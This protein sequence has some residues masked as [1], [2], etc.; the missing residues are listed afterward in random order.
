MSKKYLLGLDLGTDSVGWCL[1][2][3]NSKII[4]KNGKYLWGVRLFDEA[5]DCK[6]RRSYRTNR[7]R[8]ARRNQRIDLLQ[9]LFAEEINKVDSNFYIRLQFSQIKK[10][11]SELNNIHFD[12]MQTLFNDPNFNDKAYYEKYPTIYHLRNELMNNSETKFD[13]RLIYLAIAH[14]LKHRGN[15]LY[16]NLKIEDNKID[17]KTLIKEDYKIIFE[18]LGKE[19][20]EDFIDNITNKTIIDFNNKHKKTD[21]KEFLQDEI[22][23]KDLINEEDYQVVKNVYIPLLSGSDLKLDTLIKIKNVLDEDTYDELEDDIKKIDLTFSKEEFEDNYDKVMK[24]AFLKDDN[25]KYFELIKNF[26]HIYN[27][28]SLNKLLNDSSSISESMIKKYELHNSQLNEFKNYLKDNNL[29][30]TYYEIFRKE[31]DKTNNYVKYVG[32]NSLN[33]NTSRF[34]KCK[35]DDFYDF[36]KKIIKKDCNEEDSYIKKALELIENK[37]F[38]TKQRTSSNGLLPYQLVKYELERILENQSKFYPFLLEEDEYGSVKEKVIKILT[39]KVPYY[40]GPLVRKENDEN[41][42]Y[43]KFSWAEFK[44]NETKITPWNF[45]KIIDTKASASNFIKR[46]QNKCTYLHNEFCLPK[47][48]PLIQYEN[49]L[50]E[51]NKMVVNGKQ[52]DFEEKMDLLTNVYLKNDKVNKSKIEEF[53]KSK[54]NNKVTLS[55]ISSDHEFSLQHSLSSFNQLS[56]ILNLNESE[57]KNYLETGLNNRLEDIVWAISIYEDKTLLVDY[58]KDNSSRL[59]I[60]ENQIKQLKSLSYNGFSRLSKKLLT[61]S[62]CNENGEIICESMIHSMIYSNN[63]FMEL[64]KNDSPYIEFINNENQKNLENKDSKDFVKNYIND[65]YV[66]PGMKR[67]LIQS[68]KIIEEL[69]KIIGN[70][71][72]EYY[73]EC[74][75]TN[76]EKDKNKEKLS[77]KADL[78]KKCKELTSILNNKVDVDEFKKLLNKTEDT[79]FRSDAIY[80]YFTQLGRD[81]YTGEKIDFKNG[82]YDIDHIYPQSLIKDD[83]LNNRVLT[84]KSNNNKKTDQYPINYDALCKSGNKEFVFKLQNEL[85]KLGLISKEKLNRLQRQTEL[86]NEELFNFTNRQIVYTNQSVKALKDMLID[87]K[88]TKEH[89]IKVIMSKAN[90]VSDFRKKYDI[91][92]SRDANNFHHA[93]DAFLNVVVGR[94]IDTYFNNIIYPMLYSKNKVDLKRYTTNVQ[95]IFDDY[96]EGHKNNILDSNNNLVWDYSNSL[97]YI[98]KEV[99]HNYNI[100]LTTRTYIDNNLFSKV[101]IKPAKDLNNFA[102]PIKNSSSLKGSNLSNYN[103]YGGYSDLKF[104]YYQLVEYIDKNNKSYSIVSYPSVFEYNEKEKERFIKGSYNIDNYKVIIP[105]LKINTVIENSKLKYC[106]T[107]RTNSSFLIKNIKETFYDEESIKLIKKISKTIDF[108]TK[109]KAIEKNQITEKFYQEHDYL[110]KDNGET[111][112]VSPAKNDNNKEILLSKNE[113]ILFLD[114]FIDVLGRD[115]LNYSNIQK[116]RLAIKE[117]FD[118]IKKFNVLTLALFINECISFT[119]TDR[120]SS[121]LTLIGNSKDSGIIKINNVLTKGIKIKYYSITGYY[122]KTIWENK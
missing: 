4:K 26:Y 58:L 48:S 24:L 84:F 66:S 103:K 41:H 3:E 111:F 70:K 73:I 98:K 42:E 75:R 90:I 100:L 40:V 83:S 119:K 13:I 89:S 33:G 2:D 57:K 38:L 116:P 74:T 120:V 46:M 99:Y 80:L 9:K 5:K 121:N 113:L 60:N 43:K 105:K 72:D 61:E 22:F 110:F 27:N 97:N 67:P 102:L 35:I 95:K 45:D 94:T 25:K 114:K 20:K 79:K 34:S 68:Y 11:D 10:E 63:V 47:Y 87:L 101:S 29:N 82:K 78:I 112:I 8:L 81:I 55:Y 118:L 52:L 88:N 86:S 32:S 15:F 96:K 37:E 53:Y 51:I 108:L 76:N 107:G 50:N 18:Q 85:S 23:S 16:E 65:L 59:N 28:L 30:N 106:I 104:S 7:R 64:L 36:L 6:E 62:L 71:I 69:E 92:K 93:H 21:K 115:Y 1:C 31:D 117:N 91:V 77:R 44:D 14:I 17:F 56:K 109:K 12:Y 54:D 49:V 19:V 122:S 39:F